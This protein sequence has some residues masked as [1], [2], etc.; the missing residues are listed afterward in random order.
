MIGK[1]I[2]TLLLLPGIFATICKDEPN[3]I[4]L[5]DAAYSCKYLY[6]FYPEDEYLGIY[7]AR[8]RLCRQPLTRCCEACTKLGADNTTAQVSE[9]AQPLTAA[10]PCTDHPEGV[11]TGVGSRDCKY[12]TRYYP[13]DRIW[14][15]Y[16]AKETLCA[17]RQTRCCASCKRISEGE[18]FPTIPTAA[19]PKATEHAPQTY[20]R[21]E[22]SFQDTCTDQCLSGVGGTVPGSTCAWLLDRKRLTM[23]SATN[24]C[25]NGFARGCAR[26]C[27]ELKKMAVDVP[28]SAQNVQE[29]ACTD[30]PEGV[31]IADG[32]RDCKYLT[33]LYTEDRIWGVYAARERLCAD[34]STRCCASC[35][36]VKAEFDGVAEQEVAVPDVVIVPLSATSTSKNTDCKDSFVTYGKLTVTC[37]ELRRVESDLY[38]SRKQ[39]CATQ[40]EKCCITCKHINAEKPYTIAKNGEN[41]VFQLEVSQAGNAFRLT[42]N[43]V[44]INVPVSAKTLP[45]SPVVV[46]QRTLGE[47]IRRQNQDREKLLSLFKSLSNLV[48]KNKKIKN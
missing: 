14:G 30:L 45:E 35:K 28:S 34:P 31:W 36:V 13:E 43:D 6:Q 25:N 21:E 37:S 1:E 3:G 8:V 4:W 47:F 27:N 5:A 22:P 9:I 18:N 15:V 11:W 42:G 19:T 33:R 23:K 32:S 46:M 44:S 48:P 7:A 16:A 24:F 29:G 40:R 38:S 26:S 41:E 20:T 10:T 39:L 17:D 12:L 2:S